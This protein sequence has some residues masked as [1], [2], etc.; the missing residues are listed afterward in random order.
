MKITI[1][2]IVLVITA[3]LYINNVTAQNLY[4][5]Y[6]TCT[7]CQDGIQNGW[8][9]SMN[10]PANGFSYANTIDTMKSKHITSDFGRRGGNSRWH[11]GVDYSIVSGNNDIGDAIYPIDTGAVTYIKG[12]ERYKIICFQNLNGSQQFGYG[13]IFSRKRIIAND[14]TTAIRNGNFILTRMDGDYVE[15]FSIIYCPQSGDT[16]AYAPI[17]TGTVTHPG[18]NRGQP[19][20]VTNRISPNVPL[21]SLG[22]SGGGNSN[23]HIHLYCLDTIPTAVPTCNNYNED[24]VYIPTMNSSWGAGNALGFVDRITEYRHAK[25]PLQFLEHD[26]PDYLLRVH[27]RS[28]SSND[29]L[30]E[31]VIQFTY[32]GNKKSVLFVRVYMKGAIGSYSYS[33]AVMD[34]DKV[35]LLIKNESDSILQYNSI[36]GPQLE[37][38]MCFG[39]KKDTERY[40]SLGIPEF[41]NTTGNINEFQMNTNFI[42][43]ADRLRENNTN[44]TQIRAKA[45]NGQKYDDF[46]FANIYTRIHQ[47]DTLKGFSDTTLIAKVNDEARYPDGKYNLAVRIT[48]VTGKTKNNFS[49][50]DTIT[51][52][53][54]RPYVKSVEIYPYYDESTPVA[55]F[56]PHLQ[57]E[58]D[59]LLYAA[60]WLFDGQDSLYCQYNDSAIIPGNIRLRINVRTSE[61]VPQLSLSVK[62]S[63]SGFMTIMDY[64]NDAFDTFEFIT[65][66]LPDMFV[67]YTLRFDGTDYAGNTIEPF[68]DRNAKYP[69]RIRTSPSKWTHKKIAGNYDQCHYFQTGCGPLND[70]RKSGGKDAE[71][72]NCIL[73]YFTHKV[74]NLFVEFT[75]KSSAGGP[76]ASWNWDFGDGTGSNEQF[77]VHAYDIS[78]VYA[79]SLTVTGEVGSGLGSHTFI[80]TVTVNPDIADLQIPDFDYV[81]VD[82]S[83]SEVKFLDRS[84]GMPVNWSWYINGSQIGTGSPE[85]VYKFPSTSTF[86]DIKLTVGYTDSSE[87]SVSKTFGMANCD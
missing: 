69:V 81:L 5:H 44:T 82:E 52:D 47:D 36:V 73:A 3:Y 29:T 65:T 58:T 32:P 55:G 43:I 86:Y 79:V 13:H 57:Q 17:N 40:P 4:I 41:N 8:S 46:F 87:V 6:K 67:T 56:F 83:S 72:K 11:M 85:M 18:I 27:N 66:D 64:H 25:N 7:S 37:S 21:V 68:S 63:N 23:G 28:Y 59:T 77:P 53:N 16:I 15:Y 71:V 35:E 78:G 31:N 24:S 80:D 51:I 14:T 1:I 22:A 26:E 60:Q 70:F 19:L 2:K 50:P 39:G 10:A 34:L 75:D 76:I 84:S 38:F 49:T 30:K 61:P 12:K 42:D 48:T 33:N 62:N 74:N 20:N 54:F 9:Q 45:Y